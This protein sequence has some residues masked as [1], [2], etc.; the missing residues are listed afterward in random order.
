MNAPI[1]D[2]SHKKITLAH[3]LCL[4]LSSGKATR[5]SQDR[6]VPSDGRLDNCEYASLQRTRTLQKLSLEEMF[7][8][9][10][11]YAFHKSSLLKQT[12]AKGATTDTYFLLYFG[13]STWAKDFV[14]LSYY[15]LIPKGLPHLEREQSNCWFVIKHHMDQPLKTPSHGGLNKPW[16]LRELRTSTLM[17]S[18]H[19]YCARKFTCH[20]MHESAH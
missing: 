16:K 4:C 2:T 10:G 1:S 9:P 8:S 13:V 18:T 3:L 7:I 11:I 17:V 15:K 12:S 20:V 5:S 19:P 14:L 6:V